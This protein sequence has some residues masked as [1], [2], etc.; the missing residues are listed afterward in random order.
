M[1]AMLEAAAGLL[2]HRL[3]VRIRG[4]QSIMVRRF[5]AD[6]AAPTFKGAKASHTSDQ[7]PLCLSISVLI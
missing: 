5:H 7:R 1:E 3:E 6:I 2:E 4:L